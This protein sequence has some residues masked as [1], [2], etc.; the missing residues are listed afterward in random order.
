MTTCGQVPTHIRTGERPGSSNWGDQSPERVVAASR[1]PSGPCLSAE[2]NLQDL[3]QLSEKPRTWSDPPSIASEWRRPGLFSVSGGG[4]L[5]GPIRFDV[6]SGF[7]RLEAD[8]DGRRPSE[9]SDRLDP[10]G[11]WGARPDA[12]CRVSLPALIRRHLTY[13]LLMDVPGSRCHQEPPRDGS[14]AIERAAGL[15]ASE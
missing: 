7:G 9:A 15:L 12:S 8:P 5:G 3:S 10:D 14:V 1:D 2:P 6:A 11:P 13:P 4:G